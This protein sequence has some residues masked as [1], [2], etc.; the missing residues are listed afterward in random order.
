MQG[1][2]QQ[3][4]EKRQHCECLF[5]LDRFDVFYVLGLTFALALLQISK[6]FRLSKV[7]LRFL[8][9]FDFASIRS[10]GNRYDRNH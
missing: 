5:G 10:F 8:G 7:H 9:D 4:E 3:F 6:L 1:A 2:E